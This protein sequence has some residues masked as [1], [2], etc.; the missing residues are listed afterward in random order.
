MSESKCIPCFDKNVSK[1]FQRK[2]FQK[3]DIISIRCE[4]RVNSG[5]HLPG[6]F[7]PPRKAEKKKSNSS[8]IST[9]TAGTLRRLNLVKKIPP[10]YTLQY[11]FYFFL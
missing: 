3:F 4:K 11:V 7:S 8:T 10:E 1:D 5:E 9:S 6:S 2:I